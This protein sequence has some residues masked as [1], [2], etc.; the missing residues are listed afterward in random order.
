MKL[1]QI[2]IRRPVAI[3]MVYGVVLFTGFM[4]ASRLP[5]ELTPDVDFPRLTVNTSWFDSSPEAMEALVT[6]P[7][8][9]GAATVRNVRKIKSTSEE[10]SSRVDLE[11]MRGTN[12]DFAALELNEKLSTIYEDLPY[13]ASQPQIQKY[14]PEEFQTGQFLTYHV[15]GNYTPAH[16][17]TIAL[18]KIRT[19]LLG[20]KGV[21]DVQIMG[22]TDPEL[23]IEIDPAKLRQY[24]L[25]PAQ[26]QA[27]LQ[28]LTIRLGAGK[29]FVNQRKFDILIDLPLQNLSEIEALILLPPPQLLRLKDVGRVILTHQEP[30]Q[31]TRIDGAAAVLLFIERE[32]GT[33]IIEVADR[34]FQRIQNLP[35]LPPTVKL[36]K[37]ADQSEKIRQELQALTERAFFSILIIFLVLL[38]FLRSIKT[39]VIILSNIFFAVL[40]TLNFFY[41]ADI[42]LNLITL[43]GLALGFGMLVDNSIVVVE[44]IFARH[45]QGLA[46]NQAAEKGTN[47]VALAIIAST[48]TTVVVF[49]PFLYLTGELQIYYLP[50]AAAVGLSLLA[51]L[52][53][54][55]TLTPALTARLLTP[56]QPAAPDA[57]QTGL[58]LTFGQRVKFRLR[59][60][61]PVFPYRRYLHWSLRHPWLVLFSAVLLLVGSFYLFNKYVTRGSIWKW[62]TE[63]YLIVY[64][65]MPTGSELDRTDEIARFFESKT[66]GHPELKQVSAE[67]TPEFARLNITFPPTLEYTSVPI[68]W[69]ELLISLATQYAGVQVGVHGFGPGFYGG[70]GSSTPAF[71]LKVLGYN[72]N[73][74]KY[75]AEE[76]GRR[77]ARNARVREV[78]TNSAGWYQNDALFE[79]V[80]RP[81]REQLSRYGLTVA[82]LL[83]HLQTFL[84]ERLQY[85]R[86]QLGAQEM[87]YSIKML[88]ARQFSLEDLQQLMLTTPTG[89]KLRLMQV[90]EISQRQVI[91]EIVRENQQYQRW[92]TFEYRGP[93]KLGDR[94]VKTIIQNTLLPPGYKLERETYWFMP[95]EEEQQLLLILAIAVGLIFMVTAALFESLRQPLTIILTVPMALIGVF[96]IFYWTDTNF[97]RNAYIGVML[98]SGIVVNN[99]IVLID[100]INHLR[101]QGIEL[102]IAIIQGCQDRLRPISMTSA[103]TILGL[104]PLILFADDR[105]SI[106]YALALSTIGGLVSSVGLVLTVLPVL[107][108][109]FERR[110]SGPRIRV[111]TAV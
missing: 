33:N 104:L 12:M 15:V 8:E 53:V 54:A 83:T 103:T 56:I 57:T 67:V 30:R 101:R 23:R 69:K 46:P 16:L 11:F 64:I 4:A 82:E 39:A 47:E 37:K 74:V 98:L 79:I 99:A 28:Q 31:F 84:R 50:F 36:I 45:Q 2:C 93:Y 52:V 80:L 94:F 63:T 102:A 109:L 10:G 61:T 60:F 71:R 72:Y 5:L 51:S 55:F 111:E 96:L 18:E 22:G 34:V 9:A 88:N 26:I 86:I 44:N 68:I 66:V 27:A 59:Q 42:G 24:Q 14:V 87:A 76:I 70:G 29:I 41:F 110:K 92:I 108:F 91:A 6:A 78:N 95:G 38:I 13:G 85:Q 40:I 100:H 89:E 20:V 1:T 58:R 90:A 105:A 32:I 75:L 65:H 17:R 106:W 21:A 77:L 3:S 107:Y 35:Q 62:G 49:F 48:L 97:D 43:A 73:Q 7:I 19:P 81:Q 25:D